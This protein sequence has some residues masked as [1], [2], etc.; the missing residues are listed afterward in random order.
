MLTKSKTR[1]TKSLKEF[2]QDHKL[3]FKNK[4]AGETHNVHRGFLITTAYDEYENKRI[5]K[6]W[7]ENEVGTLL[8]VYKSYSVDS[9][10][11]LIDE[12]LNNE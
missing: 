10:K 9:A 4:P 11:R 12:E 3:F 1:Q 6:V 5:S 2:K 7:Q 8:V